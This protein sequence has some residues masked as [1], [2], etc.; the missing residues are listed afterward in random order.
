MQSDISKLLK[1]LL[2][3]LEAM[4][5]ELDSGR[6]TAVRIRTMQKLIKAALEQK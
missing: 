4:E 2:A 5:G 3:Q 1:T 6:Q